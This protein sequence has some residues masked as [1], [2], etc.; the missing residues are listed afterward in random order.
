MKSPTRSKIMKAIIVLFATIL[1]VFALTVSGS[2]EEL[3]DHNEEKRMV[4]WKR[5]Y[6]ADFDE[7][8]LFLFVFSIFLL[9]F[10]L[11]ATI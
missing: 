10:R 3:K 6:P 9:Y 4:Y 8:G 2:R 1:M 5:R 11:F 7:D